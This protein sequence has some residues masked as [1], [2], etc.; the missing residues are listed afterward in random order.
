MTDLFKH[1]MN[2]H[3]SVQVCTEHAHS[4]E[5]LKV[6]AHGDEKKLVEAF[7]HRNICSLTLTSTGLMD[8]G[9]DLRIGL[10][11]GWKMD[12]R[13]MARLAAF[14]QLSELS[15]SGVTFT[16]PPTFPKSLTVLKMHRCSFRMGVDWTSLAQLRSL[17][18]NCVYDLDWDR[19][20]A[21]LPILEKLRINGCGF[22][23]LLLSMVDPTRLRTLDLEEL[24]TMDTVMLIAHTLRNGT[25]KRLAIPFNHDDQKAVREHILPAIAHS[26]LTSLELYGGGAALEEVGKFRRRVALLTLL[27]ARKPHRRLRKI[28][29]EMFRLVGQLLF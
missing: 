16:E 20:V 1:K 5:A 6:F 14:T 19:R 15:L 29:V 21:I 8:Y 17:D 23:T 13:S 2:P 26:S 9:A 10:R 11:M 24:Y 27:L 7:A 25:L 3:W 12:P 4:P 22:T 28:P 18:L